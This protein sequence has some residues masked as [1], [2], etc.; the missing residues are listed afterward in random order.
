MVDTRVIELIESK[1]SVLTA[2]SVNIVMTTG[3]TH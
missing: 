3:F 2:N 1:V